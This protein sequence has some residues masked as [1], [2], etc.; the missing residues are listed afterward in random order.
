MAFL[1]LTCGDI[2]CY[3]NCN[4]PPSDNAK[5]NL[6]NH[7][8]KYHYG[9]CAFVNIY[10]SQV[11]LI[12]KGR[13]ALFREHKIYV[14]KFGQ[15]IH[16]L[17]NEL[18]STEFYSLDFDSFVLNGNFVKYVR[19]VITNNN[20]FNEVFRNAISSGR[21][22]TPEVMWE[23]EYLCDVLF[24]ILLVCNFMWFKSIYF[25]VKTILNK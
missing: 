1:C 9:T 25:N 8:K 13:N 14:D 5:G 23:Y 6:N 11:V 4:N 3:T 21:Y 16:T 19:D 7:A 17:L 10:E 22:F 20:M 24:N 12:S 15:C 18:S 2:V